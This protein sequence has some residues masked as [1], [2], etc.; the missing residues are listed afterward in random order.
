MSEPKVVCI[1]HFCH[2]VANEGYILGGTSAYASLVAHK[3]GANVSAITSFGDDFQ[4][5][6]H[7]IE[8][9]IA[10]YNICAGHTTIFNNQYENSKRTQVILS[11]AEEISLDDVQMI[12][13]ADLVIIGPIADE[14]DLRVTQKF[15]NAVIGG[16]LQG[17]MRDFAEDG[18]VFSKALEYHALEGYEAIILSEEDIGRD[19]VIVSQIRKYVDHF[20]LTKGDQG[21]VVFYRGREVHFPSFPVNDVDPTGAGDTFGTIY[22]LEFWKHRDIKK[23]CIAAHCAASIVVEHKGITTI[24]SKSAIDQRVTRYNDMYGFK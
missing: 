13:E 14:V 9:N 10:L 18:T 8:K 12:E 11:R 20:V 1:G 22:L 3:Q 19:Q 2:D 21:A 7:F 16:L 5:I 23:A 15:P 6:D 24:P 17:S 4:F